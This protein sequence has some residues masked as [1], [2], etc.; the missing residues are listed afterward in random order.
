MKD[1]EICARISASIASGRKIIAFCH[2]PFG[3]R[4]RFASRF[5]PE[6]KSRPPPIVSRE[7]RVHRS[8]DKRER[9]QAC[10]WRSGAVGIFAFHQRENVPDHL[11]CSF[12]SLS[13]SCTSLFLPVISSYYSSFFFIPLCR[14]GRARTHLRPL[15]FLMF[16]RTRTRNRLTNFLLLLI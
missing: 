9:E 2:A 12:S 5:T 6:Q 4:A 3:N 11:K 13:P 7:D 10:E 14:G 16:H 1:T 8:S 15:C